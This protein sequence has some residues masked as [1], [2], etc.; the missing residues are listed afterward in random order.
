MKNDKKTKVN[1][2]S[3][4]KNKFEDILEIRRIIDNKEVD[5]VYYLSKNN[6]KGKNRMAGKTDKGVV[7]TKKRIR[8]GKRKVEPKDEKK[9]T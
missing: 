5:S 8:F 9:Y 3:S 2:N 4:S 6:K 7:K 1:K